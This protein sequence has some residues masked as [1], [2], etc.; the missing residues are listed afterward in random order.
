L[1][2]DFTIFKNN[3]ILPNKISHQFLETTKLFIIIETSS[4]D[5]FK[6]FFGDNILDLHFG[7]NQSKLM[8]FKEQKNSFYIFK[9]PNLKAIKAI[10]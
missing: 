2:V 10:V 4:L 3:P 1:G 5:N 9:Q 6:F 7:N 8:H